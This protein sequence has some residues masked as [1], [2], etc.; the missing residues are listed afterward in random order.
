[1]THPTPDARA[2]VRA[3]DALTTQVRRVA[4]AME[5]PVD[6]RADTTDDTPTTPATTCVARYTNTDPMRWCIRPAHH[7]GRDHVDENGFHW[8]DTVAV[9]P[10]GGVVKSWL[11]AGARDLS[12]PEQRPA[13]CGAPGLWEDGH[14]CVRPAGHE[15]DHEA[16][17][18]CGWHGRWSADDEEQQR[19]RERD[20]AAL[21]Q[22]GMISDR[23]VNAV[24][25]AADEESLLNDAPNLVRVL[26][27]RAARGV[28]TEAEGAALRR[29]TEQLIAG[30]ARWKKAAEEMGHDRDVVAADRDTADR[31]RAEVQRDRDQ[32]AA[33]LAEVL[34]TFVHKVGGH[35]I[36][37]RSG[38]VDVV[39][40]DKWRSMVAPAVERPWWEAVAAAKADR[41]QAQ[42]AVER[43]REA[44]DN[45][46]P[47]ILESTGE[48]ISEFE[49]GWRDHDLMVRFA[50]D[51]PTETE[52]QPDA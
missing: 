25:A 38:E 29:R 31:L 21:H 43:V 2:V 15:D 1:M 47:V 35:R 9:Y 6:G 24:F 12:I 7:T 22:Q 45:R 48:P 19:A 17:D 28:L 8:S 26:V 36:P 11:A 50:L 13:A 41:D 32:H 10:T 37:R 42:A 16:S 34:A 20:A 4:D 46:P 30:R 18:G 52:Q 44:L 3:L 14:T 5:T 51:G 39:T 23:E 49:A 33:V 27:D 40:L